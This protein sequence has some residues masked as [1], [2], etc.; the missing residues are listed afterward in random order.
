M[1]QGKGGNLLLSVGQD[2]GLLVDDEYA[3][4]ASQNKQAIAKLNQ[5]P[6]KF[7]INTH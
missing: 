6:L 2:G 5:G 1:L 4:I 3:D 7:I